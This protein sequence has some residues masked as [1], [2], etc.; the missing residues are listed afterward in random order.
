MYSFTLPKADTETA[1]VAVLAEVQ[2][3]MLL[4]GILCLGVGTHFTVI[5]VV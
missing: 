1:V 4:N 2:I 5:I 3:P